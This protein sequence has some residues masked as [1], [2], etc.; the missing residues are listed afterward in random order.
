M[1]AIECKLEIP[2][3][4][5]LTDN[6]MTVGREAL[7]I[8]E[9][10]FPKDILTVIHTEKLH[11]VQSKDQDH[12]LKILQ[13]RFD[14][15]SKLFIKMTSYR[16]GPQ[17][18]PE[19]ILTDDTVSLNLGT[20]NLQVASVMK[21]PD[22][23]GNSGEQSG[24]QSEN[25]KAPFGPMGPMD[26]NYPQIYYI[27]FWSLLAALLAGLGYRI[28][29]R[30]QRQKMINRLKEHDSALSPVMQF[31]QNMRRLQRSNAAFFGG[32]KSHQDIDVAT[33]ELRKM[34]LLY[35]TRKF[36][37]PALEW[38][39][40]IILKDVKNHHRVFYKSVGSEMKGL[41]KEYEHAGSNKAKV[42]ASDVI[43]L[44]K[45]TR[46]LVEKMESSK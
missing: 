31:H 13:A 44:A 34:F 1:A 20:F 32:E 43:N 42:L 33:D 40:R 5:G 26:L 36:Q 11:F 45:R 9:G 22:S 39:P 12:L 24:Q 16:V 4:Q 30:N 27:L 37:I 14:S 19:L 25:P 18:W 38:G 17:N 10:E 28:F 21:K 41:L 29:R 23:S 3:V 46:E 7:L 8:C 35:L 15:P 6:E 2:K